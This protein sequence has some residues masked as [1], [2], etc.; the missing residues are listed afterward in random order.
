MSELAVRAESVGKRYVLGE[1]GSGYG[2]LTE[3][4]SSLPRRRR[5]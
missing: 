5:E 3:R 2:L 1:R 4:L